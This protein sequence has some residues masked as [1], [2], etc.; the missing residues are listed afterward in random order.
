MKKRGVLVFA[1]AQVQK[2][3]KTLNVGEAVLMDNLRIWDFEKK[4]NPETSP[5]IP[6]FED[7]GL[8]RA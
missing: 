7:I 1:R 8:A 2:R 4:F 3:L 5:Y 6:F